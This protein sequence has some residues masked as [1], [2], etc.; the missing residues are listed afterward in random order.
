MN[1]YQMRVER[2]I[3]YKFPVDAPSRADA[4]ELAEDMVRYD[5]V[6][7]DEYGSPEVVGCLYLG[8][9]IQIHK[10]NEE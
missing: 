10:A 2:T 7:P 6:Q 9:S 4:E 5:E 3:I 1:T 8:E